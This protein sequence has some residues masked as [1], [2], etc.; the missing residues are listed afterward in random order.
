MKD[1]KKLWSMLEEDVQYVSERGL[2]KRALIDK[3]GLFIGMDTYDGK[4]ILIQ[5][6]DYQDSVNISDCPNWEG[7]EIEIKNISHDQKAITIKLL[8]TEFLDIF[9]SLTS[10][11]YANLI[12]ADDNID[13]V[14]VFVYTL[15]KW[16]EFFKKFG[17]KILTEQR[18]RGIYGELYFLKNHVMPFCSDRDALSAWYGHSSKHQDFSFS[19]GNVEIKTTIRKQHKKVAISN[20]KQLDNTG[21]ENLFLY[22]I[23]LNQDMNSG[24]SLPELV[25]EIRERF[26]VTPNAE[27]IFNEYLLRTGYLDEHEK[28]YSKNRYIFKKEYMFR[29]DEGFPCITDPP[30]GI[31]DVKYSI[32]ISSCVDFNKDIQESMEVLTSDENKL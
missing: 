21:M 14:Q 20:E 32:V 5:V 25:Y 10:D 27:Y 28:Y 4:K 7:T 23:T 17:V 3:V 30:E 6:I 12:K 15:N 8:D 16:N 9:N 29:V 24:Q 13:A 26:L 19:H 31:G 1:I 18:Q 22:C 2:M 11:L